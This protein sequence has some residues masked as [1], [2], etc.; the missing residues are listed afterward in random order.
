MK[1]VYVTL[2]FSRLQ[3]DHPTNPRP[4]APG[5]SYEAVPRRSP[6]GRTAGGQNHPGPADRPENGK[7]S[8]FLRPGKKQRP[9][10]TQ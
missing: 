9:A 7:K 10:Q 2:H 6:G 5:H 8:R 3:N 1:F 4:A